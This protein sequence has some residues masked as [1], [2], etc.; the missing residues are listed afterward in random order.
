MH[1]FGKTFAITIIIKINN[2]RH[3]PNICV[4]LLCK[5]YMQVCN[6]YGV[7]KLCVPNVS[8]LI[9]YTA[10]GAQLLTFA[11]WKHVLQS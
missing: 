1:K 7:S 8:K 10:N 4:T 3:L 11:L 5:H 6:E 9:K 2:N